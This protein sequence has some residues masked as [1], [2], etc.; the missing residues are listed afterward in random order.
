MQLASKFPIRDNPHHLE[1]A[2][3]IGKTKNA[4]IAYQNNPEEELRTRRQDTFGALPAS[5]TTV[6]NAKRTSIL[7]YKHERTPEHHHSKPL[8]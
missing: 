6:E 5:T 1:S 3:T 4:F 8:D 2:A 7:D